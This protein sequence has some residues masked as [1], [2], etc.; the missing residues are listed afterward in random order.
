MKNVDVRNYALKKG[1]KLW[2]I[3][4]AFG[5]NDVW[6]SKKLRFELPEEQKTEMFKVIDDIAESR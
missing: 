3:A 2:E 6:I 5:H 4:A 1:V